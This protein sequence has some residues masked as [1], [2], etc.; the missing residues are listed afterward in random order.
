MK[1]AWLVTLAVLFLSGCSE[2]SSVEKAIKHHLKDPSSAEFRDFVVSDG[3]QYACINWNAKNSF[4]GYTG[5]EVAFLKKVD[6]VWTVDSMKHSPCS[7][8]N[9]NSYE[10]I[11]KTMEQITG[12][13]KQ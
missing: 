2:Q 6:G 12:I 5:W 3:N 13:P 10:N 4:G 1:Y 8:E 11:D 9:L 7:L